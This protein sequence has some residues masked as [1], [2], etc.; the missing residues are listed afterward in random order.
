MRLTVAPVLRHYYNV[1]SASARCP[2]GRVVG[3]VGQT[4]QETSYIRTQIMHHK[5]S[6]NSNSN[7]P[8]YNELNQTRK[9]NELTRQVI[10]DT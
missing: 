3:S 2:T 10:H 1:P 7:R 6:Q 4:R 9:L 8:R 5:M